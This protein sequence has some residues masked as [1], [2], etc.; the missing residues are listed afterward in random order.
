MK[1]KERR[2]YTL[3]DYEKVLALRAQNLSYNK[4]SNIVD[5]SSTTVQNWISTS[6]KPRALYA[7]RQEK[8]V[9]NSARKLSIELAYIYGVLI[10][11][12]NIERRERTWRINLN[13]KD[14]DFAQE[15][16]RNL[17]L[18]SG[19]KPTIRSR[20][21]VHNHQ[22][23]YG[24]WIKGR[25]EYTVV[26]LNSK[27]AVTFLLSRIK[28]KTYDWEIPKDILKCKNK[29]IIYSFIKGIFD[30][31][32]YPIYSG[33]NRRVELEMLGELGVPQLQRLLE[34]VG[35]ES[36]ITQGKKQKLKGT[37]VLRILRQ[38]SIQEFRDNINFSIERKRSKLNRMLNSYKRKTYK[39]ET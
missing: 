16:A 20:T 35:I 17:H 13:V 2:K 19:L 5:V 3:N 27:Q 39:P 22:T 10:G 18:W 6:R 26:R 9:L 36:T 38:R 8:P 30:S 24:D 32:G 14:I 21:Q 7:K 28:C 31:E 34:T 23:K 4:I 29:Q 37:Y 11:D 12:G 15:F 25:S 33:R 1:G